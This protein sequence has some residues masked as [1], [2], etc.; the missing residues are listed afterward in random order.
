M[1]LD[2]LEAIKFF[3]ELFSTVCGER[4]CGHDFS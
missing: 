1:P 3:F 2:T 4:N